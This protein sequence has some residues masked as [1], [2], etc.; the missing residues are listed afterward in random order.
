[1]RTVYVVT[2]P[3][4][5]H[6]VDG[7]V[8]G[9]HDSELTAR[10]R[11]HADDIAEEI[12][13]RVPE[14]A[15]VSVFS[16]DLARAAEVAHRIGARLDVPVTLDEGLREKS[17]GAAEGRPQQWL[18]D[19]FVPPPATG[20]RMGHDEGVEGAETK[21][22][23]AERVYAAVDRALASPAAHVVL[24]THGFAL[25]FVCAAFTRL[26]VEGLGYLNLR[27]RSGGITTLREDDFFH[28]RQIALLDNVDHL[29]DVGA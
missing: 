22:D 21:R 7:L 4:S 16:S 29:S 19:R 12:R 26:P 25:T 14:D 13:R 17:Y 2:H 27:G 15:S 24:V 9:W 28:N 20:D 3:E 18:D 11:A 10:G 8:G 6:H 1:V 5:A 23:F